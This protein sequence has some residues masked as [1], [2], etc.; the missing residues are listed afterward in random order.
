MFNVYYNIFYTDTNKKKIFLTL[1]KNQVTSSSSKKSPNK[2]LQFLLASFAGG[3]K[4]ATKISPL[5]NFYLFVSKWKCSPWLLSIPDPRCSK[6]LIWVL[7][8]PLYLQ[9]G[10]WPTLSWKLYHSPD[11]CQ[12]AEKKLC[13]VNSRTF[14]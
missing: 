12:S 7:C 9:P 13:Q 4:F 10:H 3:M 8:E 11:G 1:K 2:S 14:F 5:F 6:Y